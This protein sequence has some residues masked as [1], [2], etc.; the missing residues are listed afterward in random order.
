MND[1][2]LESV[3]SSMEEKLGKENF[4]LIQ[5]DLG[6]II[7]G[8]S[9]NLNIIKERDNEITTLK[10]TNEKLVKSNASLFSQIGFEDKSEKEEEK[11]EKVSVKEIDFF[12]EFD[13]KGNFK[14][15][16]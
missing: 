12:E 14:K 6:T 10:S 13:S 1:K 2:D 5:D 9:T 11:P 7:T 8:N 4:A 16:G 15:K 3:M